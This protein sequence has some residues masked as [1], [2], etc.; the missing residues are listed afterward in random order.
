MD[1]NDLDKQKIPSLDNVFISLQ[2]TLSRVSNL[3][4]KVDEEDARALITGDVNFSIEL[5]VDNFSDYLVTNKD[6]SIKLSMSGVIAS[7]VRTVASKEA[8]DT[9]GDVDDKSS[10]E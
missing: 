7:D 9:A 3:S 10:S 4:S 1:S 2:K 5:R 6:G 8:G